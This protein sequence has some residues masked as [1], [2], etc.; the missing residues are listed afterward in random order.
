MESIRWQSK[1]LDETKEVAFDTIL[2]Q[3]KEV[4]LRKFQGPFQT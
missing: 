3:V 4:E 2:N 1:R